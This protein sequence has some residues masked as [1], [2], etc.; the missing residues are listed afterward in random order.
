MVL[1]ASLAFAILLLPLTA[2]GQEAPELAE[3][4]ARYNAADFEGAIASAAVARAQPAFADAAS[5]VIGRAYLERYRTTGDPID[6]AAGREALTSVNGTALA[7]RDRLAWLVGFGQSLYLGGQPGAAAEIFETALG[8]PE[9]LNSADAP[10][11][12]DWWA[13]SLDREASGATRARRRALFERMQARME[14]ELFD[15]P[16]SAPANYWLVA[17]A[18]GAADVER[19]WSLAAAGWVRSRFAPETMFALQ[20]DLDRLVLEGVVPELARVRQAAGIGTDEDELVMEWTAFK[21]FWP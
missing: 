17:A 7:S 14:Q 13:S 4:R 5:L 9:A 1:R 16:G 20:A 12:L 18:R 10:T 2:L 11:L 19:A 21:E 3:A 6:L 15:S 8:Q